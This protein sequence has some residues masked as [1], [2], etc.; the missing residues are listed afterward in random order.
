MA[1]KAGQAPIQNPMS[2]KSEEIRLPA[3]PALESATQLAEELRQKTEL[4]TLSREAVLVVD[5]SDKI[6]FWSDDL[7]F[8]NPAERRELVHHLGEAARGSGLRRD[9]VGG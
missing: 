3:T 8:L 6:A 2:S 9:N 4:L 5:L 1:Q 7:L